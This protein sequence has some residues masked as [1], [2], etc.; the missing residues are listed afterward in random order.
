MNYRVDELAQAAGIR[1]DTVRFYQGK[2]LIP[3]PRREGRVAVYSEAHLERLRRIRDLVAQGFRLDQIKRVL[4]RQAVQGAG[5]GP[6]SD[7]LLTALVDESVGARTLSR[8]ELASEAGVP[9]VLVGAALSAGLVEALSIDG[10]ERFSEADLEMA[11]SGLAILEAGFPLNELLDLA[12]EHARNVQG[13]T[14]RAIELFDR[15]VRKGGDAPDDDA[16]V[17]DA[18]RR[19]LPLLT[20]LVAVHFQRTLVTRALERLSRSGDNGALEAALRATAD[21]ELEVACRWR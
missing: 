18:F 6:E 11:R 5:S 7:S 12:V 8:S 10:E 9:E 20:R 3:P 4:D 14:D 19:L 1:V 15:H 21:S 16:S 17:S 2:G 13:T